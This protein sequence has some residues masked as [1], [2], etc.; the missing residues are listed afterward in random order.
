M[1]LISC[2]EC[3]RKVSEKAPACPQCGAPIARESTASPSTVHGRGE[4]LF[5]KSMNCGCLV[6]LALIGLI[7]IIGIFASGT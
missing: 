5:M 7:I 4:G 2:P 1:A 3:G 6:V